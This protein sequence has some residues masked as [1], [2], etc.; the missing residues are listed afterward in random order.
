MEY[1]STMGAAQSTSVEEWYTTLQGTAQTP[2]PLAQLDLWDDAAVPHASPRTHLG[3][4]FIT[5]ASGWTRVDPTFEVVALE[6]WK[7][8]KQ[9]ARARGI[10]RYIFSV[11][12]NMVPY[13][14]VMIVRTRPSSTGF[15]KAAST[16]ALFEHLTRSQ[17]TMIVYPPVAVSA[18]DQRVRR[19]EGRVSQE[20]RLEVRPNYTIRRVFDP[21]YPPIS[22][23]SLKL[24]YIYVA[25]GNGL[26]TTVATGLEAVLLPSLDYFYAG[27]TIRVSVGFGRRVY[28]IYKHPDERRAWRNPE[29][30][31]ES[32]V[33]GAGGGVQIHHRL[34]AV[35][36]STNLSR[37]ILLLHSVPALEDRPMPLPSMVFATRS[38]LTR[39]AP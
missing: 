30:W 13:D 35:D 12:L 33:L 4:V 15:P 21:Q 34:I 19:L 1:S 38:L 9:Q 39:G 3:A 2:L 7:E 5:D 26:W 27:G 18:A 36:E 23:L 22:P 32:S 14:F 16:F 11:F 28:K 10:G 29:W 31:K 37:E 17:R 20:T 24:T 6:A 25:T 8:L